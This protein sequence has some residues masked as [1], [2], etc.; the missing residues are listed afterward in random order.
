[1]KQ[2]IRALRH[3]NFKL[4]FGGQ[5]ISLVGTWMQ[6]IAMGWLVYRLTNSPFMLGAVGFAGQIPTFL[7]APLG[8]VFADRWDRRKV[9]VFT[10]TLAMVQALVLSMLVLT[11]T[12]LIWHIFV[13][14]I[15]LGVVN[16]WDM[17]VRQSFMIEMVE[18]KED[19]SN[20]IALNSSMVNSARL[21]GPSLAGILI[22]AVGEGTCFLLNGISYLAV[23]AALLAMN[24]AAKAPPRQG[25]RIWSGL[26]EGFHYAFGFAPIW[27]L[28]LLLALVSLMGMP[29]AVLMP[30]FAKEILHGGPHTLGFLMGA[31][32]VGAIAGAVYLASR[33]SVLGLGKIISIAA[34]LFGLGLIAFS[35]SRLLGF[36]LMMMMVTGFGMIVAMAA[37][38]TVLQTIVEDDKRGRIMSFYTMTFMGMAP[39]GSLLAGFLASRMG[40]PDTLLLGGIACLLGAAVFATRLRALRRQTQCGPAV[41]AAVSA[42]QSRPMA[43]QAASRPRSK[44]GSLKPGR[45]AREERSSETTSR[46]AADTARKA[47][48]VKRAEHSI[49]TASA[50]R[51]W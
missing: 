19:L 3:R 10:Q 27:S 20:A 23:I 40:A 14:S 51:R 4:F 29:Y 28:L 25:A 26:T 17:P 22:A 16:A 31:S 33:K 2:A 1:M 46:A 8:G 15:F 38:N 47:A 9:L 30:I 35:L 43:S 11:G 6:R 34:S 5:I 18:K 50:P 48:T 44:R 42:E 36:S 37:S 49:S 13:L 12:V 21:L 24:V 7:L 41:Q 32:G 45:Q 39:F